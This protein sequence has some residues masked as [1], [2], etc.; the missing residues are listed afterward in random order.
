MLSIVIL[1]CDKDFKYIPDLIKNIKEKVHI[2][3]E[4]VLIDNR[5]KNT[6]TFNPDCTLYSFGYNARQVQGRKKGVELAK[7]D[8]I[9]FVDADD[10]VLEVGIELQS[11]VQ[12]KYDFI[13][14]KNSNSRLVS[15][16]CLLERGLFCECGVQL[17]DKWIKTDILKKAEELIPEDISGIASE[18]TMLVI[19]GLKFSRTLYFH[20]KEIYEYQRY[21]SNCAS[22]KIETVKHFK[23]IIHGYS[24]VTQ[25]I[26][27]M[28]TFSERRTLQW[29]AQKHSDVRFFLNRLQ[30]CVPKIIPE[31]MNII[32]DTFKYEDIITYWKADYDNESWVRPNFTAAR[33]TLIKRFP[34][35]QADIE[36]RS[37]FKYYRRNEKGEEYV[38]KTEINRL[39]PSCLKKWGLKLSIICLVY[40]GNTK[41]LSSFVNMTKKID[42][43]HEVVIVDNR[44]N[45]TKPLK[46]NL[47]DAVIVESEHNVGIL[48]GRR[49]GFEKS[50]GDYIWFVDIDDE[51]MDVYDRDFG[52]YDIIKFPAYS[53]NYLRDDDFNPLVTVRDGVCTLETLGRLN[54]MLWDKWFKREVI[55]NVY[56]RLP[57]FYCVYNEDT[58]VTLTALEYAK[59]VRI[60]GTR[61]MYRHRTNADS[62]T[63]KR[64]K[65][66]EDVDC[67][68]IGFDE[69]VKVLPLLKLK[70]RPNDKYN[71]QYYMRI[72]DN[73]HD[74]IKKYFVE[75]LVDKFGYKVVSD[76]I[77]TEF[78]NLSK[79]LTSE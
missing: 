23:T 7:G 42:F 74:C 78:Y 10:K 32:C 73:A 56:A 31:C 60:I 45:K 18:D 63:L 15:N 39:E 38:Y 43:K 24:E 50:S 5:E 53:D 47:D 9:W 58:L 66:K 55:E 3:Y 48:D 44:E 1:F 57:S 75:T 6:Q 14:F 77:S 29:E 22:P 4:I 8:Y 13:V 65:T 76:L 71:V 79:Y 40:D 16:Q 35:H 67:I 30:S 12:R 36:A 46:Y 25:C 11:L 70:V 68:F 64:F 49:L 52:D 28:L 59:S 26:E 41:Y 62:T 37:V 27:D 61:P 69:A 34:D 33:D 51:I 72:A 54:V 17:W 2:P 19:A 20:N 21:L